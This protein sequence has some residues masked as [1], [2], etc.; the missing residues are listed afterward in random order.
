MTNTQLT[1][2]EMQIIPNRQVQL[3]SIDT[4]LLQDMISAMK[5]DHNQIERIETLEKELH[6]LTNEY[7][8]LQDFESHCDGCNC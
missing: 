4:L 5:R 1:L 8:E 6:E 7:E 2:L 3:I